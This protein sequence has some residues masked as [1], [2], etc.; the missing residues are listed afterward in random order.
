MLRKEIL[1]KARDDLV[2]ARDQEVTTKIAELKAGVIATFNKTLDV[3]LDEAIKEYTEKY[4]LKVEAL[5]QE[6]NAE[7]TK[8]QEGTKIAREKR[9]QSEVDTITRTIQLQYAKDIDDL[10]RK[11]D[12]IKE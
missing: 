2:V 4:T 8:A 7:V 9:L 12:A 3:A 11:I 10:T 6:F 5:K 1:T